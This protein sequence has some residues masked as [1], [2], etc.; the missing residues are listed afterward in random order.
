[1]GNCEQ[2]STS[3]MRQG[4]EEGTWLSQGGNALA[5]TPHAG[6]QSDCKQQQTQQES[7]CTHLYE[8][9]QLLHFLH[10]V[11]DLILYIQT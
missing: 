7:M 9:N 2:H 10:I 6:Q 1:M 8:M 3:Q 4:L 5:A 11:T